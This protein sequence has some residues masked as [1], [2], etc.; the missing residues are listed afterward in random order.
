MPRP[1]RPF[2]HRA[3]LLA[4]SLVAMFA[5]T[6]ASSRTTK[7]ASTAGAATATPVA[8]IV[9]RHTRLVRSI[10]LADSVIK[11]S[12]ATVQ[13]WFSEKIELGL[14][15]VR[16]VGADEKS[17]SIAPLTQD[18]TKAGAPVVGRLPAPLADG[19]YTLHWTAAS[20]DGHA[21]KGS[22]SFTIQSR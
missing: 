9:F 18:A 7:T 17:V 3:L 8:A 11:A 22:F 6:A 2:A 21:V 16:I 19:K 15:R 1:A 13:L 20:G 10:P 12:P 5:M 14:S 4:S